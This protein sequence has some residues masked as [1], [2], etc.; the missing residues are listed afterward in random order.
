MVPLVL[1]VEQHLTPPVPLQPAIW[2]PVTA[3]LT[4]GLLP[5]VKGGVM[6]AIWSLKAKDPS[7]R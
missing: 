4:L 2:L 5:F 3:I 7:E 1:L 6:A